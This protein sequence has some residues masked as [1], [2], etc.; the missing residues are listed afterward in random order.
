MHIFEKTLIA[1]NEQFLGFSSIGQIISANSVSL[2]IRNIPYISGN[3]QWFIKTNKTDPDNAAIAGDFGTLYS[4]GILNINFDLVSGTFTIGSTYYLALRV[5]NNTD[6]SQEVIQI[7]FSIAQ[8]AVLGQ[9][10]NILNIAPIFLPNFT[11]AQRNALG[12]STSARLIY[13]TTTDQ[14][15]QYNPDTNTWSALSGGGSGANLSYTASPTQ[16]VVVSDTGTDATIPAADATNAGLFLP[17]EKTKL[18]SITEIFTTALKTAYDGAVTWVTTNGSSVLSHIAN[19][20][21]PHNVTKMQVGLSN[22]D[23][24]S[25]ANKPISTAT[26][27][28]LNAKQNTIVNSDSITQ[29]SSNL[30]L[31]TAER[32]KLSNTS[33]TNTGDQTTITGNAGS[34]T[35]LQ[36]ARNINGVAF[37]GS[38]NITVVDATK[39]PIITSGT[40]NQYFRGDKTFQNLDKTAVG[41]GNVDNTSDTNK[42]VSTAQQTALDLK[43]NKVGDTLAGTAGAGFFGAPAQS[44][45]APTPSSGFNL[46]ADSLGRFAWRS[47]NGLLRILDASNNTANRVY[48]FIDWDGE[49]QLRNG[50]DRK[51]VV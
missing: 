19:T 36:T 22:V 35:V 33:G 49:I 43:F 14:I 24:T 2:K 48:S 40:V 31:T 46:F 37:D 38:A 17:A 27:T 23:N 12:S 51:S 6:D 16:G 45:S 1:R 11:T 50:P 5:Y 39:E 42:P 41:L 7:T 25:D 30:F 44:S 34:A 32:V 18:S 3:F 29:G 28:A 47:A 26:Q 9:G 8:N 21:N 4:T 20:S 10:A 15:E 13:N